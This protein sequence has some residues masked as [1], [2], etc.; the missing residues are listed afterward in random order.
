MKLPAQNVNTKRCF[1]NHSIL[2]RAA[3]AAY[4]VESIPNVSGW[5]TSVLAMWLD[6]YKKLSAW[7]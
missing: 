2:G 5:G 4:Q 6:K 3:S 1:D 7:L